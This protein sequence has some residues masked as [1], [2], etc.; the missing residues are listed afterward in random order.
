[1]SATSTVLAGRRAAESLMLDYGTASRPTGG[2]VYDPQTG[3][4]VAE[5]APLF[6]SRCK[7]QMT[8]RMPGSLEVGARTAVELGPVLHLPADTDPLDVGDV[9]TVTE[10]GPLSLVPT[11]RTYRVV[12]PFEKGL[13]T[14]RRYDVEVIVS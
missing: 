2:Y 14:A 12:A 9:F 5:V 6:P 11:G 1:M 10:P 7:V 3:E 4:D 8:G 13:A